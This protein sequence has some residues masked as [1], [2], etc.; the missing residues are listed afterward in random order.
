MRQPVDEKASKL[1]RWFLRKQLDALVVAPGLKI[2][3]HLSSRRVSL[4]DLRETSPRDP[5]VLHYVQLLLDG[6][7]LND[8]IRFKAGVDVDDGQ[9]LAL[10]IVPFQMQ[11]VHLDH[12]VE[13]KLPWA[14]AHV[15]PTVSVC[16]TRMFHTCS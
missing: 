9:D 5:L 12:L 8:G 3:R 13:K 6:L 11:G 10:D 1:L 7:A 14:K 15:F 2:F 16:A 4:D